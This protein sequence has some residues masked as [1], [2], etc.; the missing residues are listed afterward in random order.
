V[1]LGAAMARASGAVDSELIAY[2]GDQRHHLH[3][4]F[5]N[6]AEQY[7]QLRLVARAVTFDLTS[8][9]KAE[10]ARQRLHG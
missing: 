6:L 8:S 9:E 7:K 2:L 10:L 5:K 4:Q 1:A 3:E